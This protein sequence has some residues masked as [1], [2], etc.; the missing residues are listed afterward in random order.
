M[1]KLY[2]CSDLHRETFPLWNMSIIVSIHLSPL[3]DRQSIRWTSD[4]PSVNPSVKKPLVFNVM[5]YSVAHGL[6]LTTCFQAI[7]NDLH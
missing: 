6:C 1:G 4:P 3:T 5:F 7:S 2:S